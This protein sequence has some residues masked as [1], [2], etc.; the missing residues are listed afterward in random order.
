[1]VVPKR[2]ENV[3]RNTNAATTMAAAAEPV[4]AWQVTTVN[5][6]SG[7]ATRSA[8]SAV[9][10]TSCAAVELGRGGADT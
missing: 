2:N 4:A 3:A 9:G 1:M 10:A 6:A 5:A 8:T 7:P